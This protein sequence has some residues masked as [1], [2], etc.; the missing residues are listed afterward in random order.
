M[1]TY[2][3]IYIY[4]HIYPQHNICTYTLIRHMMCTGGPTSRTSSVEKKVHRPPKKKDPRSGD[5]ETGRF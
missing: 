2:I 3:Y 5:P 4:T 1:Y